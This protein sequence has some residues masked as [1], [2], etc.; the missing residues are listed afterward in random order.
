MSVEFANIGRAYE[1]MPVKPLRPCATPRIRR[2]RKLHS[3]VSTTGS[4]SPTCIN[5]SARS[6]N[7]SAA[8]L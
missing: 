7:T 4:P 6:G 5:D 1:D 8:K 3:I 2:R